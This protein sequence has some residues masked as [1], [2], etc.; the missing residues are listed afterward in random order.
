MPCG[1]TNSAPS[2]VTGSVRD[3]DQVAE[4]FLG[5]PLDG[6]LYHYVWLDALTRKVR[7]CG[8]IVNVSVVPR[9]TLQLRGEADD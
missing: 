8:R 9:G 6:G 2:P 3:L 4:D 5:R 1:P 7:E